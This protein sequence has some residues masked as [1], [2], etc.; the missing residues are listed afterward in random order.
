MGLCL[1]PECSLTAFEFPLNHLEGILHLMETPKLKRRERSTCLVLLMI[2]TDRGQRALLIPGV[3]ELFVD[4]G[5][6]T[7][8]R[9]KMRKDSLGFS[10][11]VLYAQRDGLVEVT[12]LRA[13][14]PPPV[15]RAWK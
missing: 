9:G 3:P 13:T 8:V 2:M 1:A 5:D 10:R 15:K 12:M 6:A 14:G 11:R 4:Q 7:I